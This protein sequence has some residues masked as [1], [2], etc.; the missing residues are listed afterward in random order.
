MVRN[1]SGHTF[2]KNR[3]WL[4]AYGVAVLTVLAATLLRIALIPLIGSLTVPFI[5]YFPAVLFSSWYGGFRAGLLSLVLSSATAGFFFTYPPRSF[6]IANSIDQITLVVFLAVG[7]GMMLLSRSQKRALERADQEASLRRGAEFDERLQRQRF[8]TTLAS[9]GDGVIATDATGHVSFMNAAA[10]ILTG[11]KCEEALGKPLGTVFRILNE[12]TRKAVPPP[13]LSA[14]QQSGTYD[15]PEHAILLNKNGIEL[16]I[17]DSGVLIRNSE[18][19]TAGAVLTFRDISE[20]RRVEKETESSARS[21]R[22]LAAII[23]SSDDAILSKN[24][25]LRITSWNRA[26][27]RM[28]GY[29]ASEAIGQSTAIIVPENRWGEEEGL[30]LR[31]RRGDRVEHFETERRCK[32]GTILPVSLTISPIHDTWGSVVGASTIMRD[33][34]RQH[35]AEQ[36]KR[37]RLAAEE[38]NRAKDEFLAVLSHELRNPLNSIIGWVLM[39]ERGQVPDE[40]VPYVLGVIE[41]NARAE[42]Q[43]VESLLDFSRIAAHKL[44]LHMEVVDLSSLLEVIV[45]S[46]RPTADAKG[47]MLKLTSVDGPVFV[48]GDSARLQQIFSNLLTNAFKF[49]P[50]AGHIQVRL[51]RTGSRAQV[52]VVDDGEGIQGDFLPHIFERFRQAD[53]TKGRTHG[54]LGLGLAIVKELADAHGAT[55]AA[56][57]RGKGQGSTFTVTIPI[58]AVLPENIRMATIHTENA[59]E[60][61]IAGLRILVVDD[62]IDARQLVTLTLK[63]RGA[64]VQQ[65]SSA[66]EA[67]SSI[68]QEKPDLVISD[69]G[70]PQE[71]GYVLIQKLRTTERSTSQP[72]L[73]AIALTSHAGAA[74]SDQALASGYDVHLAKPVATGDLIRAVS[75]VSRAGARLPLTDESSAA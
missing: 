16:P 69:I 22:Q 12:D 24:L 75:K 15:L 48:V 38:A 10:E 35:A 64:I 47:I 29:A 58:P 74:D 73:P 44:D 23:G 28:F 60:P 52:Q 25:D 5:T 66:A 9:I 4:M 63:S 17:E 57:S 61:V 55:V 18:G 30:M 19:T 51:V 67:L 32:D 71:D 42:S 65:A 36:E 8:E 14:M 62:D 33:I 2:T 27:E 31:I 45:D 37:A 7:L 34:T 43:L 21:A 59:E 13:S 11:W 40:R 1:T 54:G 46:T 70:M 6:W 49:T 20:R 72:H 68:S 39:L 53:T 50:R 56:E 3:S 26:A 41:R